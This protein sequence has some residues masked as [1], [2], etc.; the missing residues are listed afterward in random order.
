[1]KVVRWNEG[2]VVQLAT[3]TERVYRAGD[4]GADEC[5]CFICLDDYA[6]ADV[7]RVLPCGLPAP[8]PL[9]PARGPGSPAVLSVNWPTPSLCRLPLCPPSLPLPAA[10]VPS[11][12][13]APPALSSTL[14]PC[15]PV[16]FLSSRAPG[17]QGVV[18]PYPNAP[19][20][21]VV[22]LEA[23][24]RPAVPT[25]PPHPLPCLGSPKASASWHTP[26]RA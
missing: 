8:C 7:L 6:P 11:A 24:S 4:Y 25:L 9:P 21:S 16:S 3:L 22:P 1:M 12:S 15:L 23:L 13:T 2:G 18:Q 17:R 26:L 5:T 20:S 19:A 14:S 10:S